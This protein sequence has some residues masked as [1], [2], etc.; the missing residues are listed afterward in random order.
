MVAQLAYFARLC[1]I[2]T[3]SH[4][5]NSLGIYVVLLP[6]GSSAGAPV[7]VEIAMLVAPRWRNSFNQPS[8]E[9]GAGRLSGH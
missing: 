8:P 3:E 6:I 4:R 1:R 7:V 2:R 5:K 9:S